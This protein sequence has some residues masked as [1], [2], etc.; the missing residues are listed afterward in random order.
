MS[1][2]NPLEAVYSFV[3][4]AYVRLQ[5]GDL[6][7]R[8]LEERNLSPIQSWVE[9]LVF[10]GPNNL[11]ALREILAEVHER[12][13]QSNEDLRQ[14][15]QDF[16]SNL[17]SFGVRLQ[18]VHSAPAIT[19]LTPVRF[20]SLLREQGIAE[21]E[22]QVACLQILRDAR[23]LVSGLAIHARLLEEIQTYL[24]DWLWGMVY[25]SARQEQDETSCF[26]V[27]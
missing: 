25:Q 2:P 4:R 15:L 23:D 24:E 17:H 21:E 9:G 13:T 7:F 14:V 20:L 26:L 3:E 12:Q 1:E 11:G 18:D 6:V 19:R 10:A 16:R 5:A 27:I 22:T 8:C